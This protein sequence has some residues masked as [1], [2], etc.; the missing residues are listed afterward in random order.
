MSGYCGIRMSNNA[1]KAYANGEKPYSR[2]KKKDIIAQIEEMAEHE[3][4][5]L[6]CRIED[7]EELPAEA[8]KEQCLHYSSYHHTGKY[9]SKTD[10]YSLDV[11][12][13]TEL[14][15]EKIAEITCAYKESQKKK[16]AE[17]GNETKEKWECSYLEW[18]G[19][20]D[21]RTAKRIREIG[22]IQGNWFYLPNGGK[23][24]IHAKGFQKHKQIAEP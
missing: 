12:A 18:S 15:S 4:L 1:V 20:K 21:H 23:K 17:K 13:V 14:T 3:G 22:Y 7:L 5:I 19:S 24:S 2:W 10:F 8:L 9:Y 11:F 6:N 16:K